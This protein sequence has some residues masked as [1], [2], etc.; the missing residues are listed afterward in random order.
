MNNG[1]H[2]DI[3]ERFEEKVEMI[4]DGC[5]VWTAYC[6]KDGYGR[7]GI[8]QIAHRA[9]RVAY[10]LYVDQIPDGLLVRHTC[11]NPCCVNPLHL[12]VGTVADNSRDMVV[13]G[14]STKGEKNPNSKLNEDIV[15]VIRA[16]NGT[17]TSI[18]EK[19]GVSIASIS[20]IKNHITWKQG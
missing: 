5:H 4:P 1:T 15:K 3:Y 11:D 20:M 17:I 6:D 9:H 7:F 12:E 16:E 2:R 8:G 10:E 18:A 13:R 14:R 19:Y